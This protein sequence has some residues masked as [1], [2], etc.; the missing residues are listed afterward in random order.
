M[1]LSS[2]F[3][4]PHSSIEIA[5]KNS[6]IKAKEEHLLRKIAIQEELDKLMS[7]RFFKP[8]SREDA[9]NILSSKAFSNL[10]LQD[11]LYKTPVLWDSI[12]LGRLEDASKL[13]SGENYLNLEEV[14][15]VKKYLNDSLV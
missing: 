8:K 2:L 6:R 11:K 3:K 15:L 5:H 12:R 13:S 7:K 9:L 1:K 14:E 10:A 4:I